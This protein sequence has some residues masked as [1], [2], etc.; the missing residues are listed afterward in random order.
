VGVALL[1]GVE[2]GIGDKCQEEVYPKAAAFVCLKVKSGGVERKPTSWPNASRY[3]RSGPWIVLSAL[4]SLHF[5]LFPR[6]LS[7][8]GLDLRPQLEPRFSL[9]F[10]MLYCAREDGLPADRTERRGCTKRDAQPC[11]RLWLMQ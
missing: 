4:L 1:L 11:L 10:A 7:Y 9:A 5:L 2:K 8:P 6:V 3:L